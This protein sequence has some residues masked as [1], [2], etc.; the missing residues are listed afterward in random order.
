MTDLDV[1]AEAIAERARLGQSPKSLPREEG[2]PGGRG[3]EDLVLLGRVHELRV[4]PHRGVDALEF[5]SALVDRPPELC[6]LGICV[7][8]PGEGPPRGAQGDK[9]AIRALAQPRG[10][11]ASVAGADLLDELPRLLW[12]AAEGDEDILRAELVVCRRV[13]GLRVARDEIIEPPGLAVDQIEAE[14]IHR[15]LGE[16]VVDGDR[17]VAVALPV[18]PAVALLKIRGRP[19]DVDVMDRAGADLEVDPLVRHGVGDN[20]VVLRIHL[21]AVEGARDLRAVVRLGDLSVDDGDPLLRDPVL[22]EHFTDPRVRGR[23]LA[24]D[25]VTTRRL[26]HDALSDGTELRRVRLHVRQHPPHD[27]LVAVTGVL[28]DLVAE[29]RP[30]AD[31]GRADLALLLP[32]EGRA[33]RVPLV[34]STMEGDEP[35]P[36]EVAEDARALL[37]V[38]ERRLDP[39]HEL[40]VLL[41][42]DVVEVDLAAVYPRLR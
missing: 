8:E 34:Q 12:V 15:P 16:V 31:G 22:D 20:H 24:E 11:G 7:I 27:D 33:P 13:G 21:L 32:T 4:G 38:R 41:P 29:V 3:Q 39:R 40:L 26:R 2:D 28:H 42:L 9:A 6:R 19:R 1:G 30:C 14:E 17:R 18:A 10:T 5:G 36:R 25:D 23:G 35:E 37:L